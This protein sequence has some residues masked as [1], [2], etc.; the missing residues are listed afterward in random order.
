M[1]SCLWSILALSGLLTSSFQAGADNRFE[2]RLS[3]DIEY[4]CVDDIPLKLDLYLPE[5]R[6]SPPLIVWLHGSAWRSGSKDN[7]PLGELVERGFAMASVDYRLAPVARFPA[8]VHDCMAAICQSGSL[9]SSKSFTEA[10]MV[11]VNSMIRLEWIWLSSSCRSISAGPLVKTHPGTKGA[12]TA[13]RY[14]AKVERS[15]HDT[16]SFVLTGDS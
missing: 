12:C 10:R 1:R 2:I 3:R 6:T 4:A 13:C 11:G 8:Q 16:V 15:R 9:F 7:M 14:V 5:N